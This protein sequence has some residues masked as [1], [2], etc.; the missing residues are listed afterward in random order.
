MV[1]TLPRKL[2]NKSQQ[3]KFKQAFIIAHSYSHSF[4]SVPFKEELLW[5]YLIQISQGLNYLHEKRILH[6]DLKPQNIF[7]DE[8]ENIKI[9]DMGL[10]RILGP[11]SNFAHTGVGTPLYFSPEICEEQPYNFKSDIWAFG[12]VMYELASFKPP[13]TAQNQI[14]LAK[15]V[16]SL[17]YNLVSSYTCFNSEKFVQSS[18]HL[19]PKSIQWSYS[20]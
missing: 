16:R 15:Y 5:N 4:F 19:Y 18:L 13:F 8:N 14:A 2:S 6:R 20:F 12:C 7:L 3:G 17:L 11:Q 10:G 9:G 1:V